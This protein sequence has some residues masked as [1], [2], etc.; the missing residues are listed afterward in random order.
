MKALYDQFFRAREDDSRIL[1]R[2]FLPFLY[3]NGPS[4][5]TCSKS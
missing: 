2:D 5:N 3:E 4:E 1:S